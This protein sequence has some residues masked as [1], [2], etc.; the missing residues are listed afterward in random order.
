MMSW[1]QQEIENAIRQVQEKSANDASFRLL[2]KENISEAIKQVTGKEVPQ[3]FKINVIDPSGSH[4]VVALPPV[5]NM[6]GELLE[7]ELESVAG[8]GKVDDAIVDVARTI[9]TASADDFIK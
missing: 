3:G 2:C 8:G 9:L 1:N 6:D 5:A 7:S 4:M